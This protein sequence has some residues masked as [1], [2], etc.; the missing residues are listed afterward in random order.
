MSEDKDN[1]AMMTRQLF[2]EILDDAEVDHALAAVRTWLTEDGP[3]EL[4]CRLTKL[5]LLMDHGFVTM[6]EANDAWALSR[7]GSKDSDKRRRR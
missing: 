1:P 4:D 2:Q 7:Q 5:Q 3:R 6:A